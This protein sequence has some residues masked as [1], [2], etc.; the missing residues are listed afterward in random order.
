M[1]PLD[2]RSRTT[3]QYAGSAKVREPARARS[4]EYRKQAKMKRINHPALVQF[5]R[6]EEVYTNAESRINQV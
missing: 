1:T 3:D 6:A 2:G 5:A 4:R